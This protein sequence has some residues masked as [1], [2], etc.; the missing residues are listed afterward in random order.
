MDHQD[1]C[2]L[3][4]PVLPSSASG[5]GA[6]VFRYESGAVDVAITHKDQANF[7]VQQY[8]GDLGMGRQ[9][10]RQLLR[11]RALRFWTDRP[12]ERRGR[13]LDAQGPGPTL[14]SGRQRWAEH[15]AA[16]TAAMAESTLLARLAA[17][18]SPLA[19]L[20]VP[21]MPPSGVVSLT[22]RAADREAHQGV[23][24]GPSGRRTTYSSRWSLAV[25]GRRSRSSTPPPGPRGAR[26]GPV[27]SPASS[28]CARSRPGCQ[29]RRRR[30]SSRSARRRRR[31]PQT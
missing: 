30:R 10:P 26:G 8:G 9:R 13:H 1:H 7:T 19:A 21:R 11:N 20:P 28:G 3:H 31:A 25:T 14:T 6:K 16:L 4:C 18:K 17:I 15:A 22:G 12:G 29:G 23:L 5:K 27:P 2:D 24:S